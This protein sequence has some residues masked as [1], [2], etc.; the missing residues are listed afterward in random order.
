M[1]G[2][3]DSVLLVGGPYHGQIEVMPQTLGSHIIA[4]F[5]GQGEVVYRVDYSADPLVAEFEGFRQS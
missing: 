4:A 1:S 2:T 5:G 3:G